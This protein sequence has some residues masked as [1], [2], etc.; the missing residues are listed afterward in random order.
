M[1]V[2][3]YRA[4]IQKDGKGYHGFI[5]ALP[6]CHTYDFTIEKVRKNLK[7]AIRGWAEARKSKG[8]EIPVDETIET[9]EAVEID[10]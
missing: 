9:L 7:E 10:S 5:P 3:T 8:W 1:K 2:I 4:I 6:G